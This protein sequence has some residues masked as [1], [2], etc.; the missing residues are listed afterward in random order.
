MVGKIQE[1][2]MGRGGGWGALI[3]W[4]KPRFFDPRVA[5][6]SSMPCLTSDGELTGHPFSSGQ[7]DWR[8][9]AHPLMVGGYLTAGQER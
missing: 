3:F 1:D 8:M 7:G 6:P 2:G 9:R 4:L 5:L